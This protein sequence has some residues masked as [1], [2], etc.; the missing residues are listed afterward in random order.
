VSV[1]YRIRTSQTIGATT[2][3]HC[4]LR[5]VPSK[6]FIKAP[7]LVAALLAIAS[8]VVAGDF[9]GTVFGTPC[10]GA[11]EREAALG[12]EKITPFAANVLSFKGTAFGR[13][14]I[15]TY[16][17]ESKDLVLGLYLF[18]MHDYADA[19]A[20]YQAA[21]AAFLSSDGPPSPVFPTDTATLPLADAVAP[22]ELSASWS[23]YKLVI[24]AHL[25]PSGDGSK[26]NWRTQVSV[27]PA[28]SDQKSP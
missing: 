4:S 14:V 24:H 22:K 23:V 9:R 28:G 5:L 26:H 10:A 13:D 3:E 2:P 20:D 19:A 15:I 12:S 1:I 17:C 6:V 7:S 16:V 25:T 8:P 11:N 21:Y 27:Q 18:P